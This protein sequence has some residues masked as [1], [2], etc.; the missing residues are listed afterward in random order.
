MKPSIGRIVHYIESGSD[1]H[2]AAT[3]TEV[4][5]GDGNVV[6]LAVFH[7]RFRATIFVDGV[8]EWQP[9]SELP[10]SLT[11]EAALTPFG[12]VGSWHW[13]ERED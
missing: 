12:S 8:I 2:H 1:V 9:G 11:H 3:V 5:S 10:D 4:R 7:A 13:P 6:N